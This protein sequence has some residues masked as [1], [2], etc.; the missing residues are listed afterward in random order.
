MANM[1]QWEFIAVGCA[2]HV[3]R[4]DGRHAGGRQGTLQHAEAAAQAR[5]AYEADPPYFANK[6]HCFPLFLS[7][8]NSI[9]IS[10]SKVKMQM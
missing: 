4:Q 6:F 9:R 10:L 1:T 2:Q 5:G 8:L 3:L 7:N